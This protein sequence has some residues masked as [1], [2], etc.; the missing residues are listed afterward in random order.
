MNYIIKILRLIWFIFMIKPKVLLIK[1]LGAHVGSNVK[2]YTKLNNIDLKYIKYLYIGNDVTIAKNSMIFI[3][4][5][6]IYL[7]KKYK[8]NKEK[9]HLSI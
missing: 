2:I 1:A 5:G 4:N 7:L 9:S 8:I 3:H 6:A